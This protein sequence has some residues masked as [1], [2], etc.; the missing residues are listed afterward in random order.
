MEIQTEKVPELSM[1]VLVLLVL[2]WVLGSVAA[3][4]VKRDVDGEDVMVSVDVSSLN[5]PV[6]GYGAEEESLGD[7]LREV[8]ELMGDSQAMLHNATK[9]IE[10]ENVPAES[11]PRLKMKDLPPNYHNKSIIDTK[12]GNKT[13]HTEQQILKETDNKTGSTFYAAAVFSSMSDKKTHECIVDEDCQNRSYCH[14]SFVQNKCLQ[15]KDQG[16]CIRDGECCDGQL[17]VWGQCKK[18]TKGD[19]GTIC[20]NQKKCNAGLCCTIQ[21][22]FL[23]PV[24]A[25]LSVK[26]ELCHNPVHSYFHLLS[27]G[28]GN[29]RVFD[30]CPCA[31]GLVCQRQSYSLVSICEEAGAQEERRRK[32]ERFPFLNLPGLEDVDDSGL[33]SV[34][35]N[36]DG[37]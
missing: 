9:E 24:C 7:M 20:E 26:G 33:D 15:C 18:A 36:E 6:F 11:I 29:N 16:T 5:Y 10:A 12:I 30:L 37:I 35:S 25:P 31:S 19:D 14:F 3:S 34:F 17:C 13:V 4:P 23:Y 8:E 2:P 32:L 21:T 22:R 27:W 28:W 1:S